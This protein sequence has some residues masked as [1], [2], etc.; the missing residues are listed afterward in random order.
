MSV[1]PSRIFLTEQECPGKPE[2]ADEN[3]RELTWL[4]MGGAIA[5]DWLGET[6]EDEWAD[7]DDPKWAA[8]GVYTNYSLYPN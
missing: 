1:C 4:A 5:R 6:E 2:W 3:E 7:A 8:L